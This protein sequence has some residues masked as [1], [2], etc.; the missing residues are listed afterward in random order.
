MVLEAQWQSLWRRSSRLPQPLRWFESGIGRKV[1]IFYGLNMFCFV[2][3]FFL[4]FFFA[5]ASSRMVGVGVRV[6][7]L[8]LV[9]ALTNI[10]E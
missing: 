3:F 6:G 5:R 9:G 1:W 7:G 2:C 4:L 10:E 8:V